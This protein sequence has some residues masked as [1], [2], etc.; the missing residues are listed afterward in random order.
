M[1]IKID[2]LTESFKDFSFDLSRSG[3]SRL[4]QSYKF[5]Q[6][7]CKENVKKEGEIT[8]LKG[9]YQVTLEADCDL[10]FT[11]TTIEMDEAFELDFMPEASRPEENS[12][13]E[14][15]LNS[16]DVEYYSGFELSLA[17]YFEDQILL[18]LPMSAICSD[19]CKGSCPQCGANRNTT[20]CSCEEQN[21]NNPFRVLKNLNLSD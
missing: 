4:D 18:D 7:H 3:F 15:S 8:L 6:I 12:D 19:D 9:F 14:I 10:C 17:D 13:I 11:P 16:R 2:E 5:E 20:Q 21:V 1:R